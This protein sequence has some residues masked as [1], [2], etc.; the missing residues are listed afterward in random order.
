M[1]PAEQLKEKV[2]SL[3]TQL[4]EAH[5]RMPVLLREIHTQLRADPE[6]VTTL[7]EEDISIIVNGLKKQTQTEIATSTMKSRTKSVKSLGLADL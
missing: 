2:I 3:Q 4:L 6:L 7:S 5:P 1:T